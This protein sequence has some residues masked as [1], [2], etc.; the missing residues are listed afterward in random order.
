MTRRLRQRSRTLTV[1]A[2]IHRATLGLPKAGRVDTAA[3]LRA[4]LL[5]RAAEHEAQGFTREEAE[6]LAVQ[7]MGDPQPVNRGLMGHSFT[8]RLG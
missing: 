6:Y 7:G 2:Y 5:E 1:D 4:H 3:E 8:N